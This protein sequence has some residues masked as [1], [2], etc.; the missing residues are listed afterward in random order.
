MLPGIIPRIRALGVHFGH[1]AY[2]I[3]LVLNSAR[4]I[5]AHHPATSPRFI[6]QYGVREVLAL[7][8][9]NL[10][11]SWKYADQIALFG[12][13]VIAIVL[14]ALQGALILAVAVLEPATAQ[15]SAGSYFTTPSENVPTDVV[16]IFLE[17]TFGPNLGIFGSA[18]QPLGTPV[19]LGLQQILGLYS[20]ATMVIAV[21]IVLYYILTVVGEAA[22]SGT[23]FG[24]RFNSLWAPIRL[25]IALGLLVPLGSGLNSAQ[26][27]TLWMAKMGSGL[28]TTIWTEFASTF[29]SANDIVSKP[30]TSSTTGLVSRIFM[31][32]VC[33][34]AFNQINERNG[35]TVQI[36]QNLNGRSQ[37][38][39]FSHAQ[40][41]V[42]AAKQ[43]NM[44]V[45]D[46]SWSSSPIGQPAN[47]YAC[48]H[49]TISLAD[50]DFY[51]DAGITKSRDDTWWEW[52]WGGRDLSNRIGQVHTDIRNEYIRQIGKI[53]EDVRPAAEAIAAFKISVNA[54]PGL[55]DPAT[56]QNA[57]IPEILKRSAITAH[58]TVNTRIQTSYESLTNSEFAKSE[59]YDEIVKRGWGA[60]G[61]WYGNLTKINQ[62]YMQAIDA[63]APTLGTVLS[64]PNIRNAGEAKNVGFFS[65]IFGSSRSSASGAQDEIEAALLL[66]QRDYAEFILRDIP[67]NSPLYQESRLNAAHAGG[68]SGL[69]YALMWMLG[70]DEI[71][72]L[73]S[74]P[75][76]D[77][78]MRLAGAG[79]ELL[80][81]TFLMFGAGSLAAGASVAGGAFGKVAGVI[82]GMGRVPAAVLSTVAELAGALASLFFI[83]A[84][85]AVV[86]GVFLAYIIPLM[87]F[88]Y[89]VFAVIAWVLEIFEAIVAMPLWALAHLRIDGE[90]MPGQAAIGG[91]QL[92]LM[93]LLRPALIVFGLIGGYVIFGAAMYFFSTL[94]NSATTI[95][96][97]E[98]AGNDLGAFG[99]FI[100]TLI[101]AFLTYNIALMCFKMID[102]V[103]KGILR[104]LGSGAQS[105]GDSR[106]DPING[107][108]D[109][110][111][112][113]V[114]GGAA[115]KQ[116]IGQTKGNLGTWNKRRNARNAGLDPDDPVQKVQVVTAEPAPDGP[117][118]KPTD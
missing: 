56:V 82:P 45:V 50:F 66:A 118:R 107:S 26:Y 18:T 80:D 62:K 6:G 68:D 22:Q 113:A 28:G 37:G 116:G 91:Y 30:P 79:H 87:P 117:S 19:Y 106:S 31:S 69:A 64:A 32:E 13:V 59:A 89:F 83:L 101:F 61:L 58:T 78:M 48:G 24:K 63:A 33:A 72:T 94:Y 110:L 46:L 103:P 96:Q 93:I 8:A 77:P 42:E 1:F 5:P 114:A 52:I 74:N 40:V 104:W 60:A 84:G 9:N 16:L 35:K 53:A 29:T 111:V 70:G 3:A 38:V 115:L 14:I 75:T 2:L 15:A 55:G 44:S 34:A 10:R 98:I 17:Q 95:T 54:K 51:S 25:V 97:Q 36:L 11:W 102:D 76:L 20:M 112:G 7:A 108:R 92:L 49:I 99:V 57:G 41:M 85:I 109:V 65:S 27:I 12:A 90:G 71:Y 67:P 23:P 39:M 47:D 43:A 100:Y 73:K 105:F 88:V 21:I 86:A 81:R 4:L